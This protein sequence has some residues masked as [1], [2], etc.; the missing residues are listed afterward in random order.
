MFLVLLAAAAMFSPARAAQMDLSQAVQTALS[1]SPKVQKSAS[2]LE[3]SSWRRVE[4]FSTF[5][6]TV[7]AGVNY[8]TDHRYMLTDINFGGGP[9]I[10]PQILP[11]TLYTVQATYGLFDGFAGTNRYWAAKSMERAKERELEWTKFQV[12]RE[13]ALQFYRTLAAKVLMDVATQNLKT[14]EDH[15]KDTGLLKKAGISTNYDILRVDVQVSEARSEILNAQD[16]AEV[17][18]GRLGEVLGQ[19]EP[20]EASGT[21]PV[22]GPELVAQFDGA[23]AEGRADLV[24]LQETTEGLAEL[25]TANAR[26]WVPRIGLFGVYNSYNNRTDDFSDRD[27]FRDAYQV[28]LSLTW[29]FFDGFA[30]TARA[31]QSAEQQVQAEKSLL[32]ARLH[33]KQDIDFWKRKYVYFC[34]VY[35]S[36]LSDVAKSKETVRLAREGRRVGVR[37]S[38]DLLDAEAELYR[39][40][41]GAVNAQLGSIE[42]LINLELST[43]RNTAQL[44]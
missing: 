33:S 31:K 30:S 16:N 13:V 41:A 19:P 17:A 36:R 37:T 5:L 22:L 3:E 34:T 7:T 2:S 10:V 6:P 1:N 12:E 26:H 29:N 40:Q 27:N 23:T 38:T 4:A 15:S 24:A 21:L 9:I 20:V 35:R 14:L 32:Q 8:L 44:R 18:K 28:G 43:G 39:A 25:E 42:A 11:T